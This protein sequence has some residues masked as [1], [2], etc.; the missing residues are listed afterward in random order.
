V[1][2]C[3]AAIQHWSFQE[4]KVEGISQLPVRVIKHGVNRSTSA[5]NND[6]CAYLR[7]PWE[8]ARIIYTQAAW[9]YVVSRSRR[10]YSRRRYDCDKRKH[11][12][13]INSDVTVIV[14]QRKSRY[15]ATGAVFDEL[16]T[17]WTA[18]TDCDAAKRGLHSM[19]PKLVLNC[20]DRGRLCSATCVA[21][22]TESLETTSRT[23]VQ[24]RSVCNTWLSWMSQDK[25]TIIIR[26]YSSSSSSYYY[27]YYGSFLISRRPQQ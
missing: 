2:S 16:T 22:A 11:E 6:N 19:L 21:V 26:Y 9:L 15:G 14:F 8:D 17:V 23:R 20:V 3:H 10:R 13:Y 18:E 24:A 1:S 7:R 25:L 12:S 27:K 4:L 5:G